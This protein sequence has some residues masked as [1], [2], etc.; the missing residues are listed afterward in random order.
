MSLA[1]EFIIILFFEKFV[2][3]HIY[4]L[5]IKYKSK[6]QTKVIMVPLYFFIFLIHV[7]Y[8]TTIC[9]D[10]VEIISKET[11][12]IQ[13]LI[14]NWTYVY[15]W[16]SLN[17]FDKEFPFDDKDHVMQCPGITMEAITPEYVKEKEAE[18]GDFDVPFNWTDAKLKLDAPLMKMKG[19]IL[20][21]GEKENWMM[22]ECK[23]MVRVV[24]RKVS[25]DYI[26]M[27][28]P[29]MAHIS[30]MIARKPPTM[31]ELKCVAHN[32]DVGKGMSGFGLCA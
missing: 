29:E 19:G 28:N 23:K 21:I 8:S 15:H 16:D 30:E 2:G 31:E 18:C 5:K 26:V 14:G 10:G 32:A 9:K 13:D 12:N 20:V 7:V 1:S 22:L 4:V 11:K 17:K 6:E 25:E 27:I 24:M 3:Q